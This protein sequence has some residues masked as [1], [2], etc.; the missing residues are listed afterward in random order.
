MVR[1]MK[2]TLSCLFV[3][4][5]TGALGTTFVACVEPL[6]E[7]ALPECA[8]PADAVSPELLA[9]LSK[10]RAAHLKADLAETDDRPEEA[11]RVLDAL[12]TGQLPAGEPS[13]EAREVLADTLART[14]ELRS[15]QGRFDEA[16]R[17][18]QRGLE[19]ATER[20]HYRGRLFEVL[21]AVESRVQHKLT[22]DGDA[23]GAARAKARA[24]EALEMAIDIQEEV[25]DKALVDPPE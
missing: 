24:L 6:D 10:A 5:L 18:L 7:T 8:S 9:F 21:G 20:T 17:D 16:K 12:V 4:A 25:I 19:L 2:I 3:A 1:H 11:I 22:E 15:S 14:A 23:S 13:P